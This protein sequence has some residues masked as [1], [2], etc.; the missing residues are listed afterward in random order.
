MADQQI[1]GVEDEHGGIRLHGEDDG[2]PAGAG[3]VGES[4]P[5]SV[6]GVADALADE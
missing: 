2:R 1:L 6:Q 3:K 4:I 5:E